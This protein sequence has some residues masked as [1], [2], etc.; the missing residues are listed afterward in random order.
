MSEQFAEKWM[1]MAALLV[2]LVSLT[3]CS[4]EPLPWDQGLSLS[5]E[6]TVRGKVEGR[7]DA[8]TIHHRLEP[9]PSGRFHLTQVIENSEGKEEGSWEKYFDE[10]G[11]DRD[12]KP[13]SVEL[14]GLVPVWMPTSVRKIGAKLHGFRVTGATSWIGHEVWKV[15]GSEGWTWYYDQASGLFVGGRFV[16]QGGIL[17]VKLTA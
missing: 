11:V 3:G 17:L 7:K 13:Y 12:G 10:Y 14:A 1:T 2:A 16:T 5:Y 4:K 6:V 9:T 8:F 15:V